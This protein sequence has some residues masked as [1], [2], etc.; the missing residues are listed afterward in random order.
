MSTDISGAPP[1]YETAPSVGSTCEQVQQ[2]ILSLVHDLV[3]NPQLPDIPGLLYNCEDACKMY[4]LN[5]STLLQEQAIEGHTA[6]YWAII[7]HCALFPLLL[8]HAAPLTWASKLDIRLACFVSSNQE[9]FQV[10]KYRHIVPSGST[11]SDNILVHEPEAPHA[12]IAEIQ[13]N[14]WQKR[15]RVSGQVGVEFIAKGRIWSLNFF[16]GPVIGGC[17]SVGPWQVALSLLEQSPAT[18]VD[19][20]LTVHVPPSHALQSSHAHSQPLP[21]DL[22]SLL[23]FSSTTPNLDKSARLKPLRI[24]IRHARPLAYHPSYPFINSLNNAFARNHHAATGKHP[25]IRPVHQE[26]LNLFNASAN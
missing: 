23:P 12:F 3:T 11:P 18:S 9:L 26:N 1:S 2:T 19:S 20:R 13:M 10:M 4:N 7:N 16:S 22:I 21:K 15:M 6:M 8:E 25:E 14:M 24:K 17:E 5:F